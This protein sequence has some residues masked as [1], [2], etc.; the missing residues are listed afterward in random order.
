M[1]AYLSLRH[2]DSGKVFTGSDL[3]EVDEML[4]RALGEQ[5]DPKFWFRGWMNWAGFA[6]AFRADKPIAEALRHFM[7]DGDT[8]PAAQEARE[9][10]DWFIANFENASFH[11]PR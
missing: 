8:E 1:A 9:V 7:Q 2:T 5:P 4:A 11:R 3:I 10:C 6:M